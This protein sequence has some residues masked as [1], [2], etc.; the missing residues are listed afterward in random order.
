M[1]RI[2]KT[3]AGCICFRIVS[4][5]MTLE[6][7]EMGG[8][9][10]QE[11]VEK[12]ELRTE[13]RRTPTYSTHSPRSQNIHNSEQRRRG[14]PWRKEKAIGSWKPKEELSERKRLNALRSLPRGTLENVHWSWGHGH[15]WLSEQAAVVWEE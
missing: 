8:F 2:Q 7:L 12:E 14:G 10:K 9:A 13:F 1:C 6:A 3:L 15:R 4:L 5:S 11:G